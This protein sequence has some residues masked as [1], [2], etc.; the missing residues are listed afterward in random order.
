[1]VSMCTVLRI[2]RVSVAI[3]R[4]VHP[5]WVGTRRKGPAG[6][7]PAI[8]YE[9]GTRPTGFSYVYK[10]QL[11]TQ[12][13]WIDSKRCFHNQFYVHLSAACNSQELSARVT[14]RVCEIVF[15]ELYRQS[16]LT[17]PTPSYFVKWE[18]DEERKKWTEQKTGVPLVDVRMRQVNHQT[19]MH[20]KLRVN[21]S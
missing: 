10:Y 21:V 3:R 9:T 7:G 5:S 8:S 13:E 6:Q 14:F 11:A 15:R 18:T 19:Y 2:G 17:T 1:M 16:A 4:L 12:V 20:S